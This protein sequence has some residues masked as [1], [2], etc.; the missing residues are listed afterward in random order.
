MSSLAWRWRESTSNPENDSAREKIG[1]VA[2][3]HV[4]NGVEA[5]DVSRG[6]MVAES[7]IRAIVASWEAG[8][9]NPLVYAPLSDA[10]IDPVAE[11]QK[12]VVEAGFE[13]KGT[14]D[15]MPTAS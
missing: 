15:A 12:P 14:G 1:K 7:A 8:Y 9:R 2:F 4:P 11:K 3:L 13:T 5:A 10:A 6:V